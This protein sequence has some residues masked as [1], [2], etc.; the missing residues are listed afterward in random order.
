MP[1]GGLLELQKA[2]EGGDDQPQDKSNKRVHSDLDGDKVICLGNVAYDIPLDSMLTPALN[3]NC[4]K[5]QCL[6]G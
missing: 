4:Y 1:T 6:E 2:L 5:E 3:S